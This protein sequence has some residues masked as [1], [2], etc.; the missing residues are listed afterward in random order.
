MNRFN[1]NIF[2]E[3]HSNFQCMLW[4]WYLADDSQFYV[5]GAIMLI[6]A[7]RYINCKNKMIIYKQ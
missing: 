1:V 7:A 4:S 2:L 3:F 5:L 6:L